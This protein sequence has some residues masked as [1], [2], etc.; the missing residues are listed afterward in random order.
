MGQAY[1]MLGVNVRNLS[2]IVGK[3]KSSHYNKLRVVPH[4]S[5]GSR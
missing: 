1:F 4:V 2:F 3:A 5:L